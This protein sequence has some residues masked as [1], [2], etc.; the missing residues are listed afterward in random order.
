[1][2]W[3]PVERPEFSVV[4]GGAATF[5]ELLADTMSHREE[6]AAVG[7]VRLRLEEPRVERIPRHTVWANWQAVHG[8][9]TFEDVSGDVSYHAHFREF[10]EGELSTTSSENAE[11][12]LILRGTWRADD[13][14]GLLRRYVG[15]FKRCLQCQGYAT[16]LVRVDGVLKVRCAR[17]RCENV[18]G[19]AGAR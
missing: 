7:G 17:C 19:C 16:G 13:L 4:G 15:A 8:A 6:L 10:L 3:I 2:E 1:V 18:T 14:R 11:G 9:L 12:Q 5:T